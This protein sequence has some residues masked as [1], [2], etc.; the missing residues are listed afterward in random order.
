[1]SQTAF[2]QVGAL[3]VK[4]EQGQAVAMTCDLRTDKQC[5]HGN[6][7][8]GHSQPPVSVLVGDRFEPSTEPH[9]EGQLMIRMS[10]VLDWRPGSD[11]QAFHAECAAHFATCNEAI[12]D[13]RYKELE[14]ILEDPT[15][16]VVGQISGSGP[17]LFA[18]RATLH[19]GATQ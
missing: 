2:E 4:T 5:P 9:F 15:G 18:H 3:C 6:A 16:R 13:A 7:G 17:A 1:M 8:Y 19:S 12:S 10:L 14:S 11:I